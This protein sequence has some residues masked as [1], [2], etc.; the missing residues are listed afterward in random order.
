MINNTVEIII[1]IAGLVIDT[2][3]MTSVNGF[4]LKENIR[5]YLGIE[6][7]FSIVGVLIGSL[8]LLYL[9]KDIFKLI[10]GI[11][12]IIIQIIGIIGIEFPEK[13]NAILLG[14][15]SLV[16]FATLSWIYIPILTVFEAIAITLGS[17]EGS[18]VMKYVPEAVAEY[19]PH[20]VMIMIG[21][22]MIWPCIF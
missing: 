15:D 1:I 6:T 21:L 4:T 13:V 9:S 3:I 5:S 7:L 22:M 8:V 16:I 19:L 14:S 17:T 18:N 20:F 11:L 2:F 10:C 12:I